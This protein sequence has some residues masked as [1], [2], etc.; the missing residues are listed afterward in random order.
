MFDGTKKT[1]IKQVGNGSI[2]KRF[3][4]TPTPQT[5]GDIACPHFLELKWALG[6]HFD[7]AWCYLRGSLRHYPRG[8]RFTLKPYAKIKSH[9]MQLFRALS[10]EKDVLNAGEVA[11]SL[12]GEHLNPPFTK[13]IIPLFEKQNKYKLLLLT[14]STNVNNLLEINSHNQIIVSFSLN[15]DPIARRWEKAPS[16]DA[17]IQ[18]AKKVFDAGYETRIRIDPIVPYPK[19]EWQRHYKTLIDQVFS[20]LFPERITLGSLRGLQSTINEAEDKSWV[21]FLKEPSKWGKRIPFKQRRETF[22]MILD[23]LESKYDYSNVALCKEPIMMWESLEMNWRT[24]RC[25]CV[26]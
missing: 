12:A 1:L 15:A 26:W 7:C 18:A 5:P 11:D 17:R 14:K 10:Y 9:V 23:Y 13:F 6:C 16:V 2:I 22:R 24:C 21:E 19:G 8:K 20:Q 4:M 3:E 25:N